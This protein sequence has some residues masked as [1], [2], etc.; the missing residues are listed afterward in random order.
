MLIVLTI[1]TDR[2][3]KRIL[4][5]A[6]RILSSFMSFYLPKEVCPKMQNRPL[7]KFQESVTIREAK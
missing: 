7:F 6:P 2:Q 3:I 5:K 4:G 1:D